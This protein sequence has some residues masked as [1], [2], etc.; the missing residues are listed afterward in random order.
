MLH[1]LPLL[2]GPLDHVLLL[3]LCVKTGDDTLVLQLSEALLRKL[4]R[5]RRLIF[6]VL[7]LWGV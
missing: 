6:Q 3:V 5:V 7:D 2:V 4:V 1:W